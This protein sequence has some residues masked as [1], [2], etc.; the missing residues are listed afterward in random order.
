VPSVSSLWFTGIAVE[1]CFRDALALIGG[2]KFEDFRACR[3]AA[4]GIAFVQAGWIVGAARVTSTRLCCRTSC[5][6]SRSRFAP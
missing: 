5:T 2:Y 6:G 1:P 4:G 3:G